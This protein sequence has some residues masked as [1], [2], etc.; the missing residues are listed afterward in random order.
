[1]VHG[2]QKLTLVSILN[3]S[4]PAVQ[5]FGDRTCRNVKEA[6]IQMSE[7]S[8]NANEEKGMLSQCLR[9]TVVLFIPVNKKT[10]SKYG[11]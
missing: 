10:K 4:L 9:Q 1:M 3:K 2:L 8:S 7:G 11:K 5:G 6:R